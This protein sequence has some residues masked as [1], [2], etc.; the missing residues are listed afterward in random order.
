MP[1]P[2]RLTTADIG[3]LHE[4]RARIE[5]RCPRA[6]T[7]DELLRL[8]Y[9]RLNAFKLKAGFRQLFGSSPQ[10][11]YQELRFD[12][13]RHYLAAGGGVAETAYRLNYHSATTF[14][15]AFKQR[16][17]CTPKQYK[18]THGKPFRD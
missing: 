6:Y 9:P 11:Y 4:I 17:G 14:I 15:K 1:A 12:Q 13:A 7:H 10:G 18:L 2:I 16:S 5:L 8:V 3:A